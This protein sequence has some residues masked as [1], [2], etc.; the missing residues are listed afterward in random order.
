MMKSNNEMVK[1]NKKWKMGIQQGILITITVILI[2][3]VLLPLYVTINLSLK[4]SSE[5][6][7][8]VLK[9][10]ADPMWANYSNSISEIGGYMINS[11]IVCVTGTVLLLFGSA[12]VAYVFARYEFKCKRLCFMFFVGLLAVPGVLTLTPQFILY[13]NLGMRN[14]WWPLIIQYS[15]GGLPGAVFLFTSFFGQLPSSVFEAG[16]IDGASDF[17]L[18]FSICMPLSVTIMIIQGL[19]SLSGQYN[20][21]LWPMMMIDSTD[22]QLIIPALSSLSQALEGGYSEPGIK[23]AL[24]LLS[25]IPLMFITIGGLK[26]FINGD[27]ASGMKL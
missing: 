19:G 8:F 5:M 15:V 25:G 24:Y 14:T 1:P 3:F 22:K 13:T 18:F 6:A 21:Y 17:R 11:V 20:D 7:D 23:Y 4:S 12:L 10:A 9:P 27:F 16:K 26:Y 2:F